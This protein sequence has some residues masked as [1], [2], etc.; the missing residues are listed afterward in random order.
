M[1]PEIFYASNRNACFSIYTSD[2]QTFY[3]RPPPEHTR[4][5]TMRRGNATKYPEVNGS[6]HTSHQERLR[7]DTT[8][9]RTTKKSNPCTLRSLFEVRWA[10][11][12]FC[13]RWQRSRARK[14]DRPEWFELNL[15]FRSKIYLALVLRKIHPS[16][17]FFPH[18]IFSTFWDRIRNLLKKLRNVNQITPQFNTF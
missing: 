18:R 7:R 3:I 17:N 6:I 12:Q 15:L 8:R 10:R 1:W 5:D 9:A 4:R 14:H 2:V 16:I 13:L 11:G